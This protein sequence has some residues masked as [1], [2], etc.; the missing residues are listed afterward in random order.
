MKT[1]AQGSIFAVFCIVAGVVGLVVWFGVEV[2]TRAIDAL[3][4][5]GPGLFV[6]LEL[7]LFGVFVFVV[8]GGAVAIVRWLNLRS[9]MIH[10]NES[11]ALYPQMYHGP[12]RYLDLNADKSQVVAALSSGRRAS[13]AVTQ[14]VLDWQPAPVP[15]L[16]APVAEP[17]TPSEVTAVDPRTS[18]HW[19]LVGSTGSGKTV[20]SYRI[21]S[22][23]T[24]RNPCQVT[25]CEPGGVNW[26][27]Q[28][29]ATNT[30]EIAQTIADVHGELLRRQD[31]LRT[32]DVDHVQDLV[33][34]LPYVVLV[35]EETETVLDD[36]KLTDRATRD[37]TIIALRSIARLGRKCGIVLVAVTQSGTTDV[38]DSH[39][40]R[41][42][43]NV[44]LFRSDHGMA[45][46]WRLPGV[47]LQDLPPGAAYSVRHS[48]VV[49]FP[50]T[51]RPVLPMLS[52]PSGMTG[53]IAVPDW[54]SYT[55]IPVESIPVPAES[56]ST[57][58]IPVFN[59]DDR[60]AYT[61]GQIAHIQALYGRLGSIKAVERALY[62]QDGGYWFYRLK[63]VL[64]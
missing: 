51:A 38:F 57:S 21:L 53:G 28:A 26:A 11:T 24:R 14:R 62:Q 5:I 16:P 43:S 35:A 59:T 8:V 27:G 4:M 61:D 34:P 1:L 13:A 33:P 23:L 22:E 32:A 47:R 64:Q 60:T 30:R 15:E 46:M 29:T 12:A 20:A 7:V 17:L 3:D 9:R 55:G 6:A 45:E 58:G 2:G 63:D 42:L 40:R 54:P 19:L 49:S 50:M 52:A 41:N 56:G 31:L 48:A 44:L 18:P 10:P 36:L 39:V 37:A 25:I